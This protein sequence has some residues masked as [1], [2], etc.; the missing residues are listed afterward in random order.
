MRKHGTGLHIY[1]MDGFYAGFSKISGYQK[2]LH[3]ERGVSGD[4]ASGEL[5]Y[6]SVTDCDTALH[7]DDAKGFRIVGSTLQ[8]SEYGIW[9]KDRTHYKIHTTNIEGGER[10]ISIRNGVA[11]LVN[12]TVTGE[13]EILGRRT[14]YRE[15]QYAEKLPAF[16]NAYDRIRKP[17]KVDL[18]NVQDYGAVGDGKADDTQALKKAIEA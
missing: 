3:F 12:C 5:S 17:A 18:F 16:R 13:T 14:V 4:D 7:V 10:S 11:E 9:G 15:H 2:G 8:G 1:E 6:F